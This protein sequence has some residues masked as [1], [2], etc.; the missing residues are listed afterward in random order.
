MSGAFGVFHRDTVVEAGG[1]R[2]DVIGEDMELIVRLH[3]MLS[4]RGQRYRVAFIPDPV[5]WTD[6]PEDLGTLAQASASAGS[7]GL[8]RAC[9]RI[10]SLCF[11]RGSGTAGW[12]AFPFFVVFELLS[13]LVEV[14]GLVVDGRSPSRSG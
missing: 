6:A 5:C 11:T 8:Q 12:L 14:G 1:F 9:G 10:A 3:R 4:A 7:A 13:P 2:A